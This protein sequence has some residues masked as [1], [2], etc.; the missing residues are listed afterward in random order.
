MSKHYP[1]IP[2]ERFADDTLCHCKAVEE[3]ARLLRVALGSPFSLNADASSGE[4]EDR[5]LQ[6]CK[7]ARRL[8]D[9]SFDFLGFS[10]RARKTLW[11]GHIHAH[12]FMPARIRAALKAM[13]RT[14]RRW[15][16]HHRS[17]KSLQDLAAMYNPYI[18]GWINYY[19]HFYHTQL[20]PTLTR[21]DAYVI[22]WARRKFKRL[23]HQT[24]GAQRLVRSAS[25]CQSNALRSL[26]AM[27]WQRPNIGSRVNREVHARFGSAR[28]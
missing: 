1:D 4:D 11:Q 5:L 24:K 20:R 26:A 15:A 16:L 3:Q 6:G 7:P 9:Q 25:P 8:S 23:R 13:S 17:D 28:R 21:I 14:I 22:R 2:F 18:R 19:G 10:F 27:S 12:G